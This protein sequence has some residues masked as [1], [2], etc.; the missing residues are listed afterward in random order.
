M[1]DFSNYFKD[2]IHQNHVNVSLLSRQSGINRTLLQ[3]IITGARIPS[4]ES[5]LE[6]VLPYMML[7]LRQ[8]E[9]LMRLYHIEKI[10]KEA[11]SQ[12]MIIKSFIEHLQAN[13]HVESPML[14]MSIES[15]P[16]KE[17][18]CVYDKYS[19]IQCMSSALGRVKTKKDPVV[20]LLMQDADPSIYDFIASALYGRKDVTLIHLLCFQSANVASKAELLFNIKLC[21]SFTPLLLCGCNYQPLCYYHSSAVDQSYYAPYPYVFLTDDCVINFRKDLSGALITHEP[22]ILN[23]FQD[24]IEK[25]KSIS[26]SIIQRHHRPT[27]ILQPYL[28]ELN[29]TSFDDPICSFM[30]EPCVLPLFPMEE[31][32]KKIKPEIRKDQHAMHML[33]D[34]LEKLHQMKDM[35]IYF[36]RTG[37]Y[38]FMETGQI[39]EVPSYMYEPFNMQERKMILKK[40]I[41][42]QESSH[43]HAYL[44]NN[45]FTFHQS[46]SIAVYSENRILFRYGM[47]DRGTS[48]LFHELS[49]GTMLSDFFQFLKT[50]SMV[51]KPED[52]MAFLLSVY[53]QTL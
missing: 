23:Q 38:Q 2:C 32:I 36:T 31:I 6:K 7:S 46:L 21:E 18:Y 17:T 50:S 33:Q 9:E 26:I 10:G 44:V 40:M 37:L 39:S 53:Q 19:L 3:K 49:F 4:E 35:T 51:E 20:Y 43:Y 41:E 52:T 15:E 1:S 16:K 14:K 12:H 29:K 28:Q 8:Q 24:F 27:E 11:Y 13:A 45:K 22:G 48:F 30:Q 47:D 25:R 34:Y 42:Q 5:F